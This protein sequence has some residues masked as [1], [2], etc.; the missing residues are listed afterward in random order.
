MEYRKMNKRTMKFG[1]WT[2]GHGKDEVECIGKHK[3]EVKF[4]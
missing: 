3:W 4:R 2:I 1:M